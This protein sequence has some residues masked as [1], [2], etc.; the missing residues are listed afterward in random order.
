M[1]DGRR[2]PGGR[3]KIANAL[4]AELNIE[5]AKRKFMYF[6]SLSSTASAGNGAERFLSSVRVCSDRAVLSH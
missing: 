1:F 6:N 3:M 2:L 5:N 4:D